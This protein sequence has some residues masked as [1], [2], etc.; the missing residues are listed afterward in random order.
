MVFVREHP[1]EKWMTGG[2][3]AGKNAGKNAGKHVEKCREKN[4]EKLPEFQVDF[5][6]LSWDFLR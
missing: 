6:G 3:T 4:G 2:T 5:M 1:N